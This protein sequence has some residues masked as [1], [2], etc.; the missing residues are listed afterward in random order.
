[1]KINAEK[2]K[3]AQETEKEAIAKK[4]SL[5][6]AEAYYLYGK[7]YRFAGDDLTSEQYFLKSLRILEPRGDSFELGRL[8]IRLSENYKER[9]IVR[10]EINYVKR[11]I[12]IFKRIDSQKGLITAYSTLGQLHGRL[13]VGVDFR[14]DKPKYDS[15]LY[16][17]KQAEYYSNQSKDSA[18]IAEANANIG[19]LYMSTDDIR[20]IT[21]FKKALAFYERQK[22]YTTI[23]SAM[24]N[25]GLAYMKFGDNK[26][27]YSVL[28]SANKLYNDHQVNNYL[29][30]GGLLNAFLVYYRTTGQW[31]KAYQSLLGVYGLEKNQ[32]IPERDAAIAKLHVEYETQKKEAQL[33]IQQKELELRAENERN[34]R[35]FIGIGL[36]LLVAAT[37]AS[38][39]FYRLYRKNQRIS[40][41]KQELINEQNHR[42]KNNL[43]VVS[44][45]LNLQARQLTDETA[46]KAITDS[47]LRIQSMAILHRRLYEGDELA[48]VYLPDFIKELVEEILKAFGYGSLQPTLTIDRVH[49]HADKAVPLGL[50][51]NELVTNTCKYAFPVVPTPEL[52]IFCKQKDSSLEL[53]V[54]DNGPGLAKSENN[55]AA[56]IPKKSF[57]MRLI[58]SQTDKL[59]A[60]Y[61]FENNNGAVFTMTFKV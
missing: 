44:S 21:S 13:W 31:Q 55:N 50:I 22:S 33:K 4:D 49:L 28:V 54:A 3:G 2:L 60:T 9:K 10:E 61:Q 17:Y 34:Q 40:R 52:M 46:K 56:G 58:K 47:Q 25:L 29:L 53:V 7:V 41:Q 32:F 11:A 48:K 8:Y 6:L 42:V 59:R 24:T 35:L 38:I 14:K 1:M 39:A 15:M 37:G 57:G 36:I 30:H 43:Q 26:Q 16:C 23:V 18:G 51:I 5:L 45:L 27:A 20:A 12:G 19:L